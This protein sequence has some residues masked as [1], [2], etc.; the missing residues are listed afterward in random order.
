[1]RYR[2]LFTAIV[3]LFVTMNV[4]LWR[5]EWVGRGRFGATVPAR[6]VWDKVLTSP[7][8]SFLEIRHHGAKLGR[9]NW[10]ASIEE[11][12]VDPAEAEANLPPEGMI[13]HVTGYRLDFDGNLALEDF[14]RAR[15]YVSLKLDTNQTWKEFN[16]RVNMKPLRWE[17]EA[18]ADAQEVRITAEDEQGR[19]VF[20]HSFAELRQPEVLLRELGGPTLPA[21]LA[22]L[23]V[24][25]SIPDGP[26]ANFGLQWDARMDRLP[27]G[28]ASIRVYR[29][30]A[31]LFDRYKAVLLISP[32][33]EILRVELPDDIVLTNEGMS[34]F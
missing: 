33:G 15:F 18:M 22:L 7:D 20:K 19:S 14:P 32:V 5:S 21:M 30:E 29:L 4:L 24:P 17:V 23:G 11:A 1:M 2:I 13:K 31:R 16:V 28:R 34:N 26:A 27:I 25:R 10:V 8:N 12:F 6:V 9:A 3:A